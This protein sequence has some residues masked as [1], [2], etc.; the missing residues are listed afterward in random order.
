MAAALDIAGPFAS[1]R[2][3]WPRGLKAGPTHRCFSGAGARCM[4]TLAPPVPVAAPF[5][6]Q[7]PVAAAALLCQQP[8]NAPP[9]RRRPQ[10]LPRATRRAPP[11]PR[12][13]L[14]RVFYLGAFTNFSSLAH[15]RRSNG[16]CP[17]QLRARSHPH[18]HDGRVG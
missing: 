6:A 10:P 1:A 18:G 7:P 16:G 15:G 5:C 13:C 11:P 12:R 2:P 4:Q 3:R 8:R 14:L 17:R 9:G